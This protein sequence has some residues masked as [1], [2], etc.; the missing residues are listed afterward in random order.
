MFDLGPK[1]ELIFLLESGHHLQS[2]RSILLLNLVHYAYILISVDTSIQPGPLC[3]CS[4]DF[5]YLCTH[6]N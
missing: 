6:N 4:T 3:N 1:G 5:H 2:S